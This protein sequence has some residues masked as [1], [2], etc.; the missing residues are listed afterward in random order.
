[1]RYQ[2]LMLSSKWVGREVYGSKDNCHDENNR[3]P[4]EV[5]KVWHDPAS[6]TFCALA[7]EH[8]RCYDAKALDQLLESL[9]VSTTN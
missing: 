9:A 6:G 2:A 4:R 7:R 8:H 5:T 3:H 1:M